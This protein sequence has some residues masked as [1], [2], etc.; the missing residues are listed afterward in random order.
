MIFVP[1]LTAMQKRLSAEV[2]AREDDSFNVR[3]SFHSGNLRYRHNM[4]VFNI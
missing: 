4:G 3:K 1:L 2:M